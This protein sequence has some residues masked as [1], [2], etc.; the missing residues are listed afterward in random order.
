MHHSIGF[1]WTSEFVPESPLRL[2]SRAPAPDWRPR[3]LPKL[4]AFAVTDLDNGL[5][6]ALENSPRRFCVGQ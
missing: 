2:E 5:P 6:A 3:M 4:A 1:V